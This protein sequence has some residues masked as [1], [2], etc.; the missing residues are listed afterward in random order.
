MSVY[1]GETTCCAMKKDGVGCDNKAYYT[2]NNNNN[3]I[4]NMKDSKKDKNYLCGVHSQKMVREKLP[5]NPNKQNIK[6]DLLDIHE[7]LIENVAIKNKINNIKGNV[8]CYKMKMMSEVLLKDGYLNIFPNFKH[9][10]RKDGLGIPSLSPMSIGPIQHNQPDLPVSLNLENFHQ[11]NKVFPDEVDD[12]NNPL[13]SFF[14]T[15]IDMY[16]DATP[17][18][19]KVNAHK[20]IK[21]ENKK[22]DKKEKKNKNIPLYSIWVLSNGDKVKLSYFESR[23]FYCNY[24]ERATA[25]NPDFL[26]LKAKI[27]DGYNLQICGYDAYDVIKSPEEHYLDTSRPFGHELVLYTMLVLDKSDYPWRKYKTFNF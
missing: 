8:V 17:H 15:Q 5:K 3:K 16:N 13:P 4:N 12:S 18:R 14:K 19:H 27:N 9:L 22:G 21:K 7:K 25:H 23:Q 11:G 20:I 26:L 24:Y 2:V 1:Y 10:N 6:N